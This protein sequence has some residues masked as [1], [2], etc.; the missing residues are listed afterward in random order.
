M[1]EMKDARLREKPFLEFEINE[2]KT[3]AALIP[4]EG[5]RTLEDTGSMSNARR[6]MET[7]QMV[8][9]DDRI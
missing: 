6:I 8:Q 9:W 7:A 4:G 5:R 3:E 2:M 1:D